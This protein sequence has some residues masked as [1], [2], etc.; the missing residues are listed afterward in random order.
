[1]PE[2]EGFNP[3]KMPDRQE[4]EN[5]AN[6]DSKDKD[7]IRKENAMKNPEMIKIEDFAAKYNLDPDSMKMLADVAKKT[8]DHVSIGRGKEKVTFWLLGDYGDEDE[9]TFYGQVWAYA[10]DGRRYYLADSAIARRED[11]SS[12]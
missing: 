6:G 5:K 12:G 2:T 8:G 4:T 11:N 1:M 7:L 3:E 10:P 9:Q